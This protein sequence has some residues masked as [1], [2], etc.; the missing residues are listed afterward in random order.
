MFE[1]RLRVLLAGLGV[2]LL[3]LV[4]RL[5]QLQ[6]VQA[7]YYRERARRS[8]LLKPK[9]VPFARGSILDRHGEALVR[10][11][12]CWDLAVDYRVIAADAEPA[13]LV[14]ALRHWKS[15]GLYANAKTEAD[16]AEAFR[17]D[18]VRM[19]E[20]VARFSAGS[21]PTSVDELRRR[22]R[23]IHA[24]IARIRAAVTRRRGFDAPVAEEKA[25]HAILAGLDADQ[26]IRARERFES[27]PWIHIKPST[28]R[29]FAG[30]GAPLAHVLGRLGRVDSTHVASDPN[31]DDPFAKYQADERIGIS[32]V[33]FAAEAQLRGRRGQITRDRQ[34]NL[35]EEGCLDAE[36]GGDVRL[37]LDA[38]LQRRLY[39]LLGEVVERIPESSGG[40]IVVLDARTREVLAL[41]SYPSYDPNRFAELFPTLRD[42]TDR[43]PLRFRAVANRYAPGSTVKPLT[44]L[45]GLMSGKISLDLREECTGYLLPDRRD[46]WRCWK[47]HGTGQ[48]KA[49]G[50]VNVVEALTGSCNVFMY[51]LGERIGVDGLCSTFDMVG[52]GRS[53]GVALREEVWGINPTPSW[54]MVNKNMRAT[55]GTARLFAIG[56]GELAMTPIQVANLMATYAS[57]RF[58]FVTLIQTET[59]PPVWDIP[60]TAAQWRA[61]RQGI[62]GVVND[63]HGTAYRH[64]RFEHDRYALCG[65]TG[66]ATT[67]R[68]P[69][70]Y[71]I[72][73]FDQDGVE[74]IALIPAGAKRPAIDRFVALH[75]QATFDRARVEVASRWPSQPPPD[76]ERY[77]HAWFGG[78]LQALDATGQ[79]DW[80]K[81]P[82]V[83]FAV[84]VEFGGSGGRTTGPLAKRV[85]AELVAMLEQKVISSQF[86]VISKNL[87]TDN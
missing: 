59:P 4:V 19:W 21:R 44:C 63:P 17:N 9:P 49:H 23:R 29:W 13:N 48:R 25:P 36:E 33:E 64:A 42:D 71:R 41:V 60:A 81:P 54:L 14:S 11:E 53:S 1:R 78:F 66:S 40:A 38:G 86:S 80:S 15:K 10:D 65:K 16:A 73:Y 7:D 8:L 79:P 28:V 83:A 20:D 52:I 75:P 2:V 76:G 34:G 74:A 82:P 3:I 6:I 69:T 58:Q 37:T 87:V 50:F 70:A 22:A 62:Y 5:G 55:P 32:G 85:A 84:L 68:W 35:V 47:I 72:P 45:A 51:R 77:S 61:I 26:Q 67:G 27:S 56:Q 24:R 30:D 12:P 46:R 18:L 31:A 39:G 57:G 43:L